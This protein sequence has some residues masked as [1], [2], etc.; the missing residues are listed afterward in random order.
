MDEEKRKGH[1]G[2]VKW[3]NQWQTYIWI[4]YIVCWRYSEQF[5]LARVEGH[6]R[7]SSV[8]KYVKKIK[9]PTECW[10]DCRE[11]D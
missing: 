4:K 8:E 5:S 11:R 6:W 7:F 9:L 2:I 1:L 10:E 3:S